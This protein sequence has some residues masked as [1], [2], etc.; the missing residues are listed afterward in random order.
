MDNSQQPADDGKSNFLFLTQTPKSFTGRRSVADRK[1]RTDKA[2]NAHVQQGYWKSKKDESARKLKW[3]R[4]VLVRDERG[5]RLSSK[6]KSKSPNPV[7]TEPLRQGHKRDL[8]QG[9]G[10]LDPSQ[11]GPTPPSPKMRYGGATHPHGFI[12]DEEPITPIPGSLHRIPANE[13]KRLYRSASPEEDLPS[14][15]TLAARWAYESDSPSTPLDT[16]LIDPFVTGAFP[17]SKGMNSDIKH[18]TW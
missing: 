4:A 11:P 15:Q 1:V 16:S 12:I 8:Q 14:V 10:I 13:L 17:I 5:L 18:C 9:K 6:S 2:K 3:K 7:P